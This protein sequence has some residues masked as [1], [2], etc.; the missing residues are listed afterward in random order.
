MSKDEK[1][2]K[3]KKVSKA[4]ILNSKR[5]Q[6]FFNALPYLEKQGF[7]RAPFSTN[8]YGWYAGMG[9]FYDLVRLSNSYLEMLEIYI[10]MGCR[11]IGVDLNI[12]K[13]D[14]MPKS[15]SELKEKG[16]FNFCAQISNTEQSLRWDI[17]KL[18]LLRNIFTPY[19]KNYNL[20]RAITP[21]GKKLRIRQ[22]EKR[23]I[24]DFT[25]IDEFI[26]LWH[27]VCTPYTTDWNG[28]IINSQESTDNES[29]HI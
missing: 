29:H 25:N 21:F 23:L 3:T 14:P 26:E 19:Y 7:E 28:N 24:E 13:L 20:K 11:R 18:G 15:V 22:L 2:K 10:P 16:S 9:Y 8:W 17:P 6:I 12:V 4:S 1:T 27:K 5:K